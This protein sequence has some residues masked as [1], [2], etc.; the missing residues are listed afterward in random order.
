MKFNCQN[1]DYFI[2]HVMSDIYTIILQ[3]VV[4][5]EKIHLVA[6][7]CVSMILL[8]YY[9]G[10]YLLP[11]RILLFGVIIIL[12]P[13]I[14]QN[15]I[16]NWNVKRKSIHYNVTI[17]VKFIYFCLNVDAWIKINILNNKFSIFLSAYFIV[18]KRIKSRYT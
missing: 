9:L 17:D 8:S 18:F 7:Q 13:I 10:T 5:V 6:L 3:S 15:L 12:I 1:L 16:G 11:N 4:L 14:I 2:D